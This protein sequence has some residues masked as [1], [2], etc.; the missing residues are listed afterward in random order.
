[1]KIYTKTGDGGNTS[2]FGGKK[3]GKD[4]SRIDAYGNV[5]ELN[6]L[7][8]VIVSG[9]ETRFVGGGKKE[10]NLKIFIKKLLRIQNELMVL[11]SDLASPGDLKIKT[12]RVNSSFAKRL[13]IEIDTWQMELAELKNFILPGGSIISSWLHLARSVTR[14]AERSIVKLSSEEPINKNALVYINRLS[15]WLFVFSRQVNRLEK[16]EEIIWKGRG[17]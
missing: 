11:G 6:S 15:D 2:V 5:D 12:Q 1:M 14:R 3:I 8:G 4:S 10:K 16:V 17:K 13:E 7:L 9:L